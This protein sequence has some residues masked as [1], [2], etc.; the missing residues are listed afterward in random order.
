MRVG[1]RFRLVC[2][3]ENVFF[4]CE[5]GEMFSF[6][7]TVGNDLFLDESR[8]SFTF[9]VRVGNHFMLGV[10]VGKYFGCEWGIVFF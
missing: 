6:R 3:L 9:V 7:L 8:E 10:R 4:W 2:E 5:N 1:N